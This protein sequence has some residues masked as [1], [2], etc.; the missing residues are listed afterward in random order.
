MTMAAPDLFLRHATLFGTA[1][2]DL[3]DFAD[4]LAFVEQHRLKPVIDRSFPLQEAR[5]A[6][7]YLQKGHGFGKVVIRV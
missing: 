6:L 3:V 1:M 4:M 7:I 2:G 5:D